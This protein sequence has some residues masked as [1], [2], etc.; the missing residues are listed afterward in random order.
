MGE[1][2]TS[3]LWRGLPPLLIV[4]ASLLAFSSSLNNDFTNWDDNWLITT[5]PWIREVSWKNVS[6]ILDPTVDPNVRAQLGGE[7]LPVRDFSAM[8]DYALFGLEP[9]GHHVTNLVLHTLVCLLLYALLVRFFGSIALAFGASLLF[10]VHPLH[11]ESV[12]WLSS[13]KDLLAGVFYLLALLAWNAHRRRGGLG[14]SLP[15]YAAA[16]LCFALA[17]TSKYMAVTLPAAL[18]LHDWLLYRPRPSEWRARFWRPLLETLPFFIFTLLFAKLVVVRIASRGLIREWYGDGFL[19][20]LYSVFHV[21]VEYVGAIFVP[22]RLQA[23]VDH[24]ITRSLDLPTLG[25]AAFLI[26]LVG[27]GGT[28]LVRALF[29]DR[30]PSRADRLVAFSGLFFFAAISPVSNILFPMGT[31]Y[32]DR[33]LYLP[34]LGGPLILGALFAAGFERGRAEPRMRAALLRMAVA[35]LALGGVALA[36]G[37]K[38]HAYNRVWKDSETLWTDVL[39]KGGPGHHTAHF[40]LGIDAQVR[41]GARGAWKGGPLFEAAEAHLRRALQTGHESYFYDYARVHTALGTVLGFL[42][43]EAEAE[44]SFAKALEINRANIEEA[45]NDRIR[46]AEKL[47]RAEILHNRGELYSKSEDPERV[48]LAEA[49]FRASLELN[50]DSATAH[51]NLGLLLL[52]R[53]KKERGEES[54]EGKAHLEKARALDRYLAE[55]PLNLGIL[56]FNRGDHPRRGAGT[57]PRPSRRP[58]LHRGHPPGARGIRPRPCGVRTH[59]LHAGPSAGMGDQGPRPARPSLRTRGEPHRSRENLHRRAEDARR[60]TESHPRSRPSGPGGHL[61]QHRGGPPAKTE[62][63]QGLQRV[64]ESPTARSRAPGHPRR[65]LQGLPGVRE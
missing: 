28:I 1:K 59:R 36:Y 17:C 61:R 20:T 35:V 32:A 5:N 14:R 6:T 18:L 50:P 9:A 24:P 4:L 58:F 51:L 62:L 22:T 52:E 3:I 7:Y 42:G 27:F 13:R 12:A 54:L 25:A 38:T 53:E 45:T 46:E 21:L 64:S 10:A 2:A 30:D 23:C 63:R 15:F 37:V 49:D 56:A 47:D 31:L 11:V 39:R 57:A 60:R 26:G 48:R 29:R 44:A 16:F 65:A 55:A 33:Y 8:A 34:L 41:A 43:R 40:N 19:H